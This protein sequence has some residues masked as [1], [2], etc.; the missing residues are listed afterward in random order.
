MLRMINNKIVE[1]DIVRLKGTECTEPIQRKCPD[2]GTEM[3]Q[4]GWS[5]DRHGEEH[6]CPKCLCYV[7]IRHGLTMKGKASAESDEEPYCIC[8]GKLMTEIRAQL[9]KK[10]FTRGKRY[11]NG[12]FQYQSS[13]QFVYDKNFVNYCEHCGQKLTEDDVHKVNEFMG[14]HGSARA[15]QIIP[16]GYKCGKCGFET[17]F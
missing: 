16:K 2:C 14:M 13:Q 17:E 6:S 10:P 12:H 11:W 4:T 15:S 1:E 9:E 3:W 7:T 8:C 5:V